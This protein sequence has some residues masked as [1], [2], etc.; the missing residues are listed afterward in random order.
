MSVW[1]SNKIQIYFFAQR[2]EL[3]ECTPTHHFNSRR[4]RAAARLGEFAP[5]RNPLRENRFRLVKQTLFCEQT[6]YAKMEGDQCAGVTKK[7][8][9][10]R[11]KDTGPGGGLIPRGGR[12]WC[13]Q[14]EHQAGSDSE[15]ESSEEA[16]TED[17]AFIDSSSMSIASSSSG[18]SEGSEDSEEE[19]P[20]MT[21]Q[22]KLEKALEEL[23]MTRQE[24]AS[25]QVK[26]EQ[27]R[28]N[29]TAEIQFMRKVMIT[30]GTALSRAEDKI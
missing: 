13:E 29:M 11:R 9:R 28:A 22:Q 17:E 14:H 19:N 15:S 4:V 30:M 12:V 10:C 23:T 6:T 7:G 24:L 26:H 25:L 5:L 16:D 1:I 8:L 27:L 18:W 2:R 20:Q 21:V 3:A